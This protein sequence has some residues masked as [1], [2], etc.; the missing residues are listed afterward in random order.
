MGCSRGSRCFSPD[1]VAAADDIS[2]P[3]LVTSRGGGDGG[4]GGVAAMTAMAVMAVMAAMETMET[5]TAWGLCG[6]MLGR[7]E[8]PFG[9]GARVVSNARV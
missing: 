9:N 1:S 7:K 5:M 6:T 8:P 4:D 2:L 3:G